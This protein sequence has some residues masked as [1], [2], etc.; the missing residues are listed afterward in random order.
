MDNSTLHKAFMADYKSVETTITPFVEQ[1][2]TIFTRQNLIENMAYY[3]YYHN[4]LDHISLTDMHVLA[5][6]GKI[7]K[8]ILNI[9]SPLPCASCLFGTAH[10]WPWRNKGNYKNT[11]SK[12]YKAGDECSINQIIILLPG[13][14]T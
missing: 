5:K 14:I 2:K 4:L 1:L 11:R 8:K 9:K 12:S 13:L 7:P 10:R 3:Y 6:K